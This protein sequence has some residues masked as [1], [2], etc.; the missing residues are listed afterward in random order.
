MS[1]LIDTR[2]YS[3]FQPL[4]LELQ[5]QSNKNYLFDLDYLA[6][7]SVV[8]SKAAEFLQG[9]LSC[10]IRAVTENDMRQGVMC[11]L[12]GRILA[13]LDVLLMEQHQFTMV[14]PYDLRAD[15]HTLLIKPAMFSR[16][17]VSC[18]SF[19][20]FGFYMQNEND[21]LPAGL[22][23]PSERYAVTRHEHMWCYHLGGGYYLFLVESHYADVLV[24]S[25]LS[26]D[27]YRGSL[28]W[29][30]SQ[31]QR[32]RVE[33]YPGSQGMFLPHRLD[34]HH[35]GYLSFDKGCYKGQEIIARMH[36]RS[37]HKYALICLKV[38]TDCDLS[39]GMPLYD[40]D[41]HNIVAELI[42]YCPLG[43]NEFNIVVSVLN[44]YS[45]GDFKSF[46]NNIIIKEVA[47]S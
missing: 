25:F 18:S 35:S 12:K 36:Y 33:I 42:D 10:D 40:E 15:I 5:Y 2:S 26:A 30:A 29:H 44:S 4:E 8:G 41:G 23:L 16:V 7:L 11:N 24:K 21:L 17:Q 19:R 31:L 32:L 46:S 39:V 20:V 45:Q 14:M 37:T 43:N 38:H 9:Q 1:Y 28:A 3:A 34:M 22:S 27:Q 6:T 13:A 47:S